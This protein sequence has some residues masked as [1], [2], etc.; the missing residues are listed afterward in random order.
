M[1]SKLT[2][3]SSGD[4]VCLSKGNSI[5]LYVQL[6]TLCS[7]VSFPH[8]TFRFSISS[9]GVFST[10]GTL[11]REDITS[12][13]TFYLTLIA[14]D[15]A[16][17]LTNPNRGTTFLVITVLDVN[18]NAPIFNPTSYSLSLLEEM[19]YSSVLTLIATDADKPLTVNSVISYSITN[20]DGTDVSTNFQIDSSLGVV[21][22]SNLDCE[23]TSS[24]SLLVTATDGG[25]NPAPM[26]GTATISV[27][28][29][30]IHEPSK[31]SETTTCYL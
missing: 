19:D 9:T 7:S 29:Q 12:R 5:I 14:E 2:I 27:A 1:K 24:F 13:E 21:S 3:I 6:P 26:S 31:D 15:G 30:V 11:D 18:D 25:T 20:Q 10:L 8:G 22:A 23:T 28:I 4:I 17:T 16:G